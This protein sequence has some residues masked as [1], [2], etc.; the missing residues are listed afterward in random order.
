[1]KTAK[2]SSMYEGRGRKRGR[3]GG[4]GEEESSSMARKCAK[5]RKSGYS[6]NAGP[7]T[8][9]FMDRVMTRRMLREALIEEERMVTSMLTEQ[10]RRYKEILMEREKIEVVVIEDEE[11]EEVTEK[12][13]EEE[14]IGTD[15]AIG[16]ALAEEKV[17][18]EAAGGV[19]GKQEESLPVMVWDDCEWAWS[20]EEKQKWWEGVCY[21][22]W[23]TM[24]F[25]NWVDHEELPSEDDIWNLK[26][27]K[28]VSKP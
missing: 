12:K 22:Y 5:A 9:A 21:P 26:E 18:E 8:S 10:E 20:C 1:M 28:E 4:G 6:V 23:E 24:C 27:I 17:D 11:E 25:D 16:E 2:V 15:Q 19:S 3:E 13:D 7:L 14:K